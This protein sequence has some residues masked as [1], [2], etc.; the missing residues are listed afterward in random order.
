MEWKII[1][2]FKKNEK[3]VGTVTCKDNSPFFLLIVNNKV[4]VCILQ[5]IKGYKI[6]Y[7]TKLNYISIYVPK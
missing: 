3:I 5:Y 2:I 1:W 6:Q 4:W 7:L